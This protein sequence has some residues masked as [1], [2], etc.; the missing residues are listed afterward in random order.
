M[1]PEGYGISENAA[2]F[3]PVRAATNTALLQK[4]L[5]LQHNGNHPLNM[6]KCWFLCSAILFCGLHSRA[7]TGL[8]DWNPGY[9]VT[10]EEDT[11]YGPVSLL[12]GSDLVQVNDENKIKTFGANQTLMVYIRERNNSETERY[13]YPFPFHPFSDFKPQRFFEMLFSGL[14]LS[15]LSR[16]MMI[17]E[18]VPLYD[19][20]TFRT[21]YT[22]RSRLQQENFL[23]FPGKKVRQV[24][25]RKDL[26]FQLADKK[27][28]MK[29]FI[30]S[31]KL[32]TDRKEDLL[33]IVQEYNQLKTP[34]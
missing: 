31:Q 21:Y 9:V 11:L 30:T 25:N 29:K 5:H 34:K 10:S 28:E 7:Q 17:T 3:L 23:L 14:Y 1:R 8:E 19:N 16:E 20:F 15:L 12:Y 24:S 22:T 4:K 32:S 18:T 27:D 33:K 26:L 6:R 2:I 13:I